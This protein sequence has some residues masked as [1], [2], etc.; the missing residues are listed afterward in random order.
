MPQPPKTQV[1]LAKNHQELTSTTTV[2]F[3]AVV[4]VIYSVASR[5]LSLPPPPFRLCTK[6]NFRVHATTPKPQVKLTNNHRDYHS[7]VGFNTVVGVRLPSPV[8]I[9]P[10]PPFPPFG[11][12][13]KA[14]SVYT[15]QPLK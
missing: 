4:G 11:F 7:T 15:P 3:N 6:R 5:D 9:R 1:N 14:S 12:V 10:P 2:G 13:S 8:A